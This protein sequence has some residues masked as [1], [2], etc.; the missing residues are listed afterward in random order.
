MMRALGRGAIAAL[1]VACRAPIEVRG[2][3]RNDDGAG[4]LFPCDQPNTVVQ[5]S[6]SV[7]ATQYR[8]SATEPYQLLFVRLRGIRSDSGSIYF[9][10]HHFLVQEVLEIRARR[11]GECPGVATPVPP[12]LRLVPGRHAELGAV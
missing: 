11:V 7:L 6:D 8:V 9:G 1:V 3:Y 4:A 10:S 5:V 12:I 2:L